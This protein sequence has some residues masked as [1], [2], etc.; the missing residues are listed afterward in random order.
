MGTTI[1]TDYG[2]KIHDLL[3]APESLIKRGIRVEPDS[4]KHELRKEYTGLHEETL[5]ALA[6]AFEAMVGWIGTCQD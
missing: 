4:A 6:P 2:A 1:V 3:Q 5:S